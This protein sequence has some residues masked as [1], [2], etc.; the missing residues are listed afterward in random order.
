MISVT[1]INSA[2]QATI[3]A[4]NTKLADAKKAC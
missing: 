3:T 1:K 4:M 2:Q